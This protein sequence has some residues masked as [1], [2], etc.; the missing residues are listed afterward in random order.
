MGYI[1]G[2]LDVLLSATKLKAILTNLLYKFKA[3]L[4]QASTGFFFKYMISKV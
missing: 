1:P 3:I 4:I 2:T